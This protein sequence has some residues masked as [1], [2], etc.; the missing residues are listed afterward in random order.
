MSRYLNTFYRFVSIFEELTEYT[1]LIY[2]TNA[3]T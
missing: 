2:K 3:I 1:S